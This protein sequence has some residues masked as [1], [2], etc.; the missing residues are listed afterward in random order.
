MKLVVALGNPGPKYELTRHN[1]GWLALDRLIDDWGAKG[2]AKKERGEAWE[3]TRFGEK[4]LLVKPQT[5][6]NLSG[7]CV[8]PLF[9]FYKCTPEDLIVLHDEVDLP[10]MQLKIKTGGGT[11]GH[12]GLKSIDAAL[13]AGKNGYH[14]VRIGVGKNPERETA[15]HV[16]GAYSDE[17]LGQLDPVLDRVAQAVDLLLQGK[18]LEAQNQFNR[19]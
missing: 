17:E 15:D 2:P 10:P 11:A 5:F 1:V 9:H 6:M 8:G 3:A 19:K 12:N 4:V 14:R 13:G 16:L 7:Q 18:S